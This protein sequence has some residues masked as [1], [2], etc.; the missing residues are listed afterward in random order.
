[1]AWQLWRVQAVHGCNVTAFA[2]LQPLNTRLTHMII[3]IFPAM[4]I[5]LSWSWK[6]LFAV[7]STTEVKLKLFEKHH[8]AELLCLHNQVITTEM[9]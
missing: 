3:T 2:I 6:Q 9:E 7:G 4:R 8:Y 1:M 5:G